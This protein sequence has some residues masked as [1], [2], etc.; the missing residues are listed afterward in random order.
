MLLQSVFDFFIFSQKRLGKNRKPFTMYK[1]RTMIL[2]AEEMKSE[3]AYL[4][5]FD[6]PFFKIKND[7]RFTKL[8][9]IL[10]LT[11]LDELP[12][13]INLLKGEMRLIGPRPFPVE[14]AKKIPKKY[15]RRFT[16]KPGITGLWVLKGAHKLS[17]AQWMESD[18]E[19]IHKKS[20]LLNVKII[21]GTVLLMFKSLFRILLLQL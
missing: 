10:A 14:E 2:N 18:L 6:G 7:P 13:I 3:Y 1:F 17:F 19:Y 9:K 21:F 16:V 5:E 11:G 15:N 12:Q 8:G 4:N 20:F